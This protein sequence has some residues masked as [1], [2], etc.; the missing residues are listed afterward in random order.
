[1]AHLNTHRFHVIFFNFS[2][3]QQHKHTQNLSAHS[4]HSLFCALTLHI[5]FPI[6]L[7][8]FFEKK[9]FFIFFV[10]IIRTL[11]VF[12]KEAREREGEGERRNRMCLC[13]CVLKP[14]DTQTQSHGKE[15]RE[16]VNLSSF[17]SP[18]SSSFPS[19]SVFMK[20]V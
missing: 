18:S 6:L 3:P 14:S 15:N 4:N 17:S 19:L 11:W 7:D 13:L 16:Q 5:S 8:F 2:S 20:K 12:V 10:R 1:M 9:L